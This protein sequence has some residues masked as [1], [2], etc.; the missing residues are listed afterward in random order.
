MDEN[1]I[2]NDHLKKIIELIHGP[3]YVR[4]KGLKKEVE[5]MLSHDRPVTNMNEFV[6]WC[7]KHPVVINPITRLQLTL[8]QEIL[9][10]DYWEELGQRRRQDPHMKSFSFVTEITKDA[11]KKYEQMAKSLEALKKEQFVKDTRTKRRGSI[12]RII[13]K[14][15]RI[16][17][18]FKKNT[19]VAPEIRKPD[20][21]RPRRSFIKPKIKTKHAKKAYAANIRHDLYYILFSRIIVVDDDPELGR[22]TVR[23]LRTMGISTDYVQSQLASDSLLC[24][25]SS[26]R[27]GNTFEVIFVNGCMPTQNGIDVAKKLRSLGYPG[28]I[29][30]MC[31]AGDG[32]D[33]NEFLASGANAVLS[34]PLDPEVVRQTFTD[35]T[36][37]INVLLEAR[38]NR[39]GPI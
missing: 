19:K 10:E 27:E 6:S 28:I 37:A 31:T 3:S 24:V 36:P 38:A 35:L 16:S 12:S 34:R 4:N 25:E 17:Q 8:R 22:E 7:R 21:K 18:R 11:V 30:G 20:H 23:M 33:Q 26:M 14:A 1:Y 13:E 5:L 39:V 29:I 2:T 32:I 9:G 15:R